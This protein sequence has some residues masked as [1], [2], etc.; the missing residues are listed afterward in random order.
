[1]CQSDFRRLQPAV[2]SGI[3]KSLDAEHW[4]IDMTDLLKAANI[5]NEN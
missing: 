3:E 4:L 2:F 5:P 1:M